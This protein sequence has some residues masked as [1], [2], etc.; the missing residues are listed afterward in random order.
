[1]YLTRHGRK[2]SAIGT[3]DEVWCS[4]MQRDYHTDQLP[5]QNKA[6]LEW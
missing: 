4:L 1:M 2:L 6:R 3:S 5:D